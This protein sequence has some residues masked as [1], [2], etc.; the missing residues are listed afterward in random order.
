MTAIPPFF[1]QPVT[2]VINLFSGAFLSMKIKK[3]RIEF[4]SFS[5]NAEGLDRGM[6]YV[7]KAAIVMTLCNWRFYGN[8]ESSIEEMFG[9]CDVHKHNCPNGNTY[10]CRGFG[11][12][13]DSFEY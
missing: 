11:N 4:N 7:E 5:H 12:W 1:L 13:K 3:G 6:E 10:F 2:N 8:A 9:F